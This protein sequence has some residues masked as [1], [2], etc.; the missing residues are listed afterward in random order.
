MLWWARLLQP[1]RF[2]DRFFSAAEGFNFNAEFEV[3][4]KDELISG[5]TTADSSKRYEW[6]EKEGPVVVNGLSSSLTS[7]DS[8]EMLSYPNGVEAVEANN[9]PQYGPLLN[10]LTR[11]IGPKE[12]NQ[13]IQKK[14][15]LTTPDIGWW[16][17]SD[18]GKWN[19][20]SSR[21]I[22]TRLRLDLG[23][24]HWKLELGRRV[25]AANTEDIDF[26]LILTWA[27][28]QEAT[29]ENE[30]VSFDSQLRFDEKIEAVEAVELNLVKCNTD[31]RWS[32]NHEESECKNF[33]G[34]CDDG[35]TKLS[36][37]ERVELS[38]QMEAENEKGT[39]DEGFVEVDCYSVGISWADQVDATYPLEDTYYQTS[40]LSWA[41]QVEEAERLG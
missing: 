5:L 29:A 1:W 11:L 41:E 17:R 24:L 7:A 14:S 23:W 31:R 34:Q 6:V 27:D 19:S 16:K 22:W 8:T 32:D 9:S 40:S 36:R 30:T 33:N 3:A 4:E 2:A 15:I 10:Q 39:V 21:G 35:D 38:E 37:A 18:I 25:E 28:D 12:S 26:R 13:P 20:R